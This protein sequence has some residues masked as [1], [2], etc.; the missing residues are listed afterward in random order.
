MHFSNPTVF[1]PFRRDKP[2]PRFAAARRAR[3]LAS[4]VKQ[5]AGKKDVRTMAL[6]ELSRAAPL[7]STA[8]RYGNGQ[9]KFIA[10]WFGRVRLPN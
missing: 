6:D 4:V 5:I 1:T 9:L 8:K 7:T 2:R 10:R 3:L